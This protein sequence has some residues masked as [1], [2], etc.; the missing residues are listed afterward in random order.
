MLVGK[1][2]REHPLTEAE[3]HGLMAEALARVNLAGHRVLVIV[4]DGTR[5]A[6]VALLRTVLDE[7]LGPKVAALDYL[8]ALGTHQP[9]DDAALGRLLGV[10][11]HGGKA[12]TSRVFNHRWDLPE[13][14]QG[15]R[16]LKRTPCF[17]FYSIGNRPGLF[18][19]SPSNFNFRHKAVDRSDRIRYVC[20]DTFYMPPNTLFRGR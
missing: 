7:L 8:A 4:P 11:V 3:V 17:L 19:G 10:P 9:M 12:G 14:K 13:L 6:P 15:V 16:T 1:S 18:S 5:T 2:A 20:I